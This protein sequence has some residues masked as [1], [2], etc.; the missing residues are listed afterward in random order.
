MNVVVPDTNVGIDLSPELLQDLINW[1]LLGAPPPAPDFIK[2]M[3]I[4]QYAKVFASVSF[5]ET[6]TFTGSTTRLMADLGLQC[7]TIE[8]SE[9]YF[10]AAQQNFAGHANVELF[11]GDS[12][13][14]LGTMVERAMG[15]HL[16]W[17]DGH[18]SKGDTA[19]GA[20]DTPIVQ[21]LHQLLRFDMSGSVILIDDIRDFGK[22][23]YPPVGYLEGF[24]ESHMRGH[25]CENFGDIFRITP[26]LTLAG[27]VAQNTALKA[28]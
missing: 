15:P 1:S 4:L 14:L 12:S 8:L 16:F 3:T 26:K 25:V 2:K 24:V 11:F 21:E 13:A 9:H 27:M 22:G 23:E 6:G 20:N 10:R 19:R 5:I 18:Y 7:K 28:A 17:L